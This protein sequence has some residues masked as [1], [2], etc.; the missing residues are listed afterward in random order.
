MGIAALWVCVELHAAHHASMA[1][2]P[3]QNCNGI[4]MAH[5]GKQTDSNET[6]QHCHINSDP[7]LLLPFYRVY[8]LIANQAGNAA[9]AVM[10]AFAGPFV[11]P[12]GP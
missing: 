9:F 3:R 5:K 1:F 4:K 8:N 11:P 12:A 10:C 7:C 2:Q 6:F